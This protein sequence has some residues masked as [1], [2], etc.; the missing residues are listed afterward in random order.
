MTR[1]ANI[2]SFERAKRTSSARSSFGVS[3]NSQKRPVRSEGVHSA[4]SASE[5]S[6]ATT[7]GWETISRQRRTSFAPNRVSSR[8]RSSQQ[9]SFSRGSSASQRLN[10]YQADELTG[11]GFSSENRENRLRSSSCRQDS[12]FA[13][14][15]GRTTFDA[16]GI[17]DFSSSRTR[18]SGA[19]DG[20]SD[21]ITQAEELEVKNSRTNKGKGK[22]GESKF[23]QMKKK[24]SKRM[25]GRAFTKQYGDAGNSS[26]D[27]AEGGSRAA[28]Y[29][30]EMGGV[31]KRATRMQAQASPS[32]TGKMMNVS[33]GGFFR[34]RR[35]I[36]FGAAAACL[37]ALGL[38]L[39]PPAQQYYQTVRECDRLQAE[40]EAIEARNDAV[41]AKVNSLS[42]DEGVEN[43]ARDEF[44]WVTKD[45]VVV[46]V[47]G[48]TADNANKSTFQANIMPGS[49]PAPET[50]YSKFLDPF[51]GVDNGA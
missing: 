16:R 39:Y 3:K 38:F 32:S 24:L 40:Y 21:E 5:R 50:W 33:K 25:A 14:R 29:K 47:T 12:G 26:A 28:L 30:G 2:L 45:E 51:F 9:L 44:G 13:A 43:Q 20:F 41:E 48:V 15:S 27:S 23:A 11:S 31:Q 34:S 42:T 22:K 37:L 1:Q 18:R 49:V 4:G 35:F 36:A 6:S 7:F 46:N 8:A 10:A 17:D 19:L